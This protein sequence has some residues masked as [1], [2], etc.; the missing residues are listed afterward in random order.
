VTWHI[1]GAGAIGSLWA[2]RLHQ[3]GE[4]ITLVLRSSKQVE[5]F[6]CND[7]SLR[8]DSPN[9]GLRVV[10]CEATL[11]EN[12]SDTITHL[13]V[14]T[15]AFDALEAI[16]SVNHQLA[17]D[18][19]IIIMINGYGVQQTIQES[20]PDHNILFAST[21]DGA[22]TRAP[23]HTVHAAI[24]SSLIG[25][26]IK[27][28]DTRVS[29]LPD[30]NWVDN[31][32]D[33]LWRKVAINCCINPVTALHQCTNGEIFSTEE[34]ELLTNNLAKEIEQLELK[35]GFERQTPLIKEVKDV[36]ELT[37]QNRSSMLQDVTNGRR[38][39][40]E[41]INGAIVDLAEKYG[42]KVPY[43]LEMLN[44]IQNLTLPVR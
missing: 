29:P 43:N 31:I 22:F 41:H 9:K 30:A 21:T 8:V 15:K 18:A 11:A 3:Q 24:G 6:N 42:V 33:I 34:R 10:K 20:F 7:N 35:M 16:E 19:T 36:A 4:A 25:S 44:T 1:I 13:L 14:T 2:D 23:F 27:K 28:A 12:I 38:T 5:A 32:N 17:N 26:L 40:V 39:E 37:S